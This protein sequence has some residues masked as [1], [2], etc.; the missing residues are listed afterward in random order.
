MKLDKWI[1]SDLGS[2]TANYT[3]FIFRVLVSIELI[4]VHGF[5]KLG[6][7]TETAEIVPNPFSL[8][9]LLNEFLAIFA[10]VVCP[11]FII[12]LCIVCHFY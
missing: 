5:K 11:L 9:Y 3:I 2:C 10:N 1:Q 8:P 12:I 6:I 4:A 7:G